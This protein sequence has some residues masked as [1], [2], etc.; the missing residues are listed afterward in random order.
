MKGTSSFFEGDFPKQTYLVSLLSIYPLFRKFQGLFLINLKNVNYIV[1]S[2]KKQENLKINTFYTSED[3]FFC[4][5][6][7]E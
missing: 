2:N 3:K 6:S 4:I 1:Q 5:N 7:N